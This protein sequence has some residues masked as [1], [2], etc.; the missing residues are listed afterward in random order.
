MP[1]CL[2]PLAKTQSVFIKFEIFASL[3]A[4]RDYKLKWSLSFQNLKIF[5]Y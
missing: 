1:D 5:V 2:N 3:A 4:L